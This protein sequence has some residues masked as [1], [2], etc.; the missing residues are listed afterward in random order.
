[1][2]QHRQDTRPE[3]IPR[4]YYERITYAYADT[5]RIDHYVAGKKG[6]PSQE[7][8]RKVGGAA[9]LLRHDHSGT[10]ELGREVFQLGKTVLHR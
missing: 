5:A 1:M 2:R 7:E 8:G 9:H 3:G 6:A 4:E 10:A